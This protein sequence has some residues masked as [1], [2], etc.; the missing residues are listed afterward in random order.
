[1]IHLLA[2]E[3]HAACRVFA[4]RLLNGDDSLGEA[5]RVG[6]RTRVGSTG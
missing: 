6:A 2:F 1:M 4:I 5:R 3:T